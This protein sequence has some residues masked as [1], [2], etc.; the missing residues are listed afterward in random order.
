MGK[1]H[2]THGP[3]ELD[4]IHTR[5]IQNRNRRTDDPAYQESWYDE[6]CGGCRFWI[7]LS[8]TL[9][10]DYGACANSSSPFDGTIRFEHDGCEEFEES[11]RWA[12]PDDV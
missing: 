4:E 11:G 10:S 7:P 3:G 1:D 5:W 12:V 2:V 6:Q 9:G 8:G